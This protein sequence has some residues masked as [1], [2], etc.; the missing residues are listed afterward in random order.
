MSEE[1]FITV[2]SIKEANFKS[3]KDKYAL[4]DNFDVKGE[5]VLHA[6][7][8]KYNTNYTFVI[9]VLHGT[10][11]I[12]VND[13]LL[14]VKSND[15][16]VVNPYMRMELLESR[17]IFFSMFI[18]NEIANDV[19]EH[20]GI[21]KKVGVRCFCFHHYHLNSYLID[22]LV[23]DY[24][25][26]KIEQGRPY[27]KMQ[28]MTVRSFL[29]AYLA[30]LYSLRKDED[31]IIYKDDSRQHKIYSQFLELLSCFYK[32][33]R[34]VQFYADKIGIT[35]KYLSNIVHQ[36]THCSASVVIDRYVICRVKQML[37]SNDVNIKTIS[38]LYNFPNQ[39]FFGRY[40]KRI[41][42]I[43]PLEYLRKNNRKFMGAD[44]K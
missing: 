21:G 26:I 10:L 28:E 44:I 37:Y 16:L 30:H 43:S 39:S 31:E 7:R 25:L 22:L 42:G 2:E 1:D 23:S 34:S 40:F 18:Q 35:P 20:C 4:Y 38:T 9:V 3:Y 24:N 11:H 33:E 36:Y 15:Y 6:E 14:E 19:Y 27:Y 13:K 12:L 41:T 8:E 17:C 5:P 29:S 32:K